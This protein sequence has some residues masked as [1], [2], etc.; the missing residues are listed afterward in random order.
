LMNIYR[1]YAM[2][3]RGQCL[4]MYIKR[5]H[6]KN[7]NAWIVSI[8]IFPTKKECDYW[9]RNQDQVVEK[10][11]DST[12]FEGIMLAIKWLKELNQKIKKGDKIIIFWTDERRHSAFRYLKR[13][14]FQEGM[15]FS[16]PCYYLIKQ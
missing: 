13:Y 14:G 2:L 15:F 7:C 10:R 9:F 3:S 4:A 5:K 8:C 6:L 16:R 11:Q 12:G 1:R